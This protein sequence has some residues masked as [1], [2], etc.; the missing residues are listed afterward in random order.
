MAYLLDTKILNPKIF[1]Y[2][3]T[4]DAK[5]NKK[6]RV[7]T[8]NQT[9][10]TF[11]Y[12]WGD[13]KKVSDLESFAAKCI[14]DIKEG[15]KTIKQV[16]STLPQAPDNIWMILEDTRTYGITKSDKPKIVA[17]PNKAIG[18]INKV[19]GEIVYLKDSVLG[20]TPF[21]KVS[22]KNVSRNY[23]YVP[24]KDKDKLVVEPYYVYVIKNENEYEKSNPSLVAKAKS[25]LGE[26]YI[27]VVK[28]GKYSYAFD[29]SKPKGQI[30]LEDAGNK[31]LNAVSYSFVGSDRLMK[32]YNEAIGY[33][34]FEGGDIEDFR[35][36][37]VNFDGNTN[38]V[39]PKS[40]T[41]I[42]VA[43]IPPRKNLLSSFDSNADIPTTMEDNT[44]MYFNIDASSND[45]SFN[46]DASTN[47]VSFNM[48]GT[49]NEVSFNIDGSTN[50]VSF[51]FSDD[52]DSSGADGWLKRLFKRKKGTDVTA[53]DA[54]AIADP[55]KVEYTPEEV[56]IMY[57]KSGTKKPFKEWLKSDE[58]VK[59]LNNLAKFGYALLLTKAQGGAAPDK[60]NA[61][62]A[63]NDY[64]NQGAS[65][66]SD[67][68]I[69]GMHPIN[70]GITVAAVTILV[71][72][73]TW[74][75]LK[76][77]KG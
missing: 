8:C 29:G 9:G 3:D 69:L 52:E 7:W 61:P 32:S 31:V 40:N 26:D 19:S 47:E 37:D 73:S 42:L 16:G 20:L 4:I 35:G 21:L 68:N 39:Y 74:L 14:K 53:S 18:K 2:K 28:S 50:D 51:N 77:K 72:V 22:D 45:V 46:M 65:P 36:G 49:T 57:E 23:P 34:A 55:K 41:K 38:R 76:N 43:G 11:T 56:Q 15:K 48:D 63:I 75:I 44:G 67:K 6:T 12:S 71:G 17:E 1:S 27:A 66:D 60:S 59:F 70:F 33:S 25:A 30:S 64:D 58:S 10:S 24:I 62:D 5:T 54:K 13:D